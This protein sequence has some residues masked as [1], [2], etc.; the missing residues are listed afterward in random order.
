MDIM[1]VITDEFGGDGMSSDRD[2]ETRRRFLTKCGK[3]AVVTPPTMALLLSTSERGYAMAFSGGYQ[4]SKPGR[5]A[6][7]PGPPDGRPP[8]G[9]PGH[10]NGRPFR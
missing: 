2:A 8:F 1:I 6:F 10:S 7:A 4:A 9:R 3:V 5:P